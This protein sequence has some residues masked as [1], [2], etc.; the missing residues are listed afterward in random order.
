MALQGLDISNYQR[1][2]DLSKIKFSFVIIKATQG[3]WYVSGSCDEQYQQAKKLNKP[4]G[5]Y[6]YATGKNPVE[7]ADFFIANT[8]GYLGDCVIALDWEKQDN[9]LFNS[10]KDKEWCKAWCDYVKEQTG[11]TPIIY[12]QRSMMD[13]VKGAGYRLWVAEYANNNETG[14]QAK[15]WNEGKYNCIIR[16]YTSSGKLAGYNEHLDLDK[17]YGTSEDWQKMTVSSINKVLKAMKYMTDIA[18]DASHGYDQV[19]RWGPDYDC[20][21]LVI[22]C[23][24]KAGVPVKT[25]GAT[26]TGNMYNKFLKCGFKDVT[27]KVN[28]TSGYGMKA[29]D[30][31]LNTTHHTA[32][33]IGNNQICQASINEKGT[34]TGGK[35]GDQLQQQGKRGEINIRSY[36]NYPWNY[37]LR[38]ESQA[39]YPTPVTPSKIKLTVDGKWG[40]QTTKRTQQFFGSTVDGIISSQPKSNKKYWYSAMSSFSWEWIT[41]SKATGSDVILALQNWLKKKGFYKGS[42]DKLAGSMTVKALQSFLKSQ[43]YYSGEVDG[44]FGPASCKAWQKYLNEH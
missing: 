31:L 29:G 17:F 25:A 1:G 35:T 13:K 41:D 9:P 36:Y 19:H 40:T 33:Y 14:Y 30:V 8:K 42:L 43:N 26:Y 38:Y 3:T 20:S 24:E 4:R 23:Y 2:I 32:M 44:S 18:N 6:H 27:K 5:I 37:V 7:E 16:Q 21:S 22:T 10:G 12:V 15:P 11:V 34:A 39:V 28:L